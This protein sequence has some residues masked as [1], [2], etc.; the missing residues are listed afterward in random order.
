MPFG[1]AVSH[2]AIEAVPK[3][4]DV[5][6]RRPI[7]VLH[8]HSPAIEARADIVPIRARA[9]LPQWPQ[10]SC[11]HVGGFFNT[12]QIKNRARNVQVGHRSRNF[13]TSRDPRSRNHQWHS[14]GALERK[15]LACSPVVTK[16]LSVIAAEDDNRLMKLTL[17]L[18]LIQHLLEEAVQFLQKSSVVASA[19]V[20]I[21]TAGSTGSTSSNV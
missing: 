20:T 21:Y 11:S 6:I 2:A 3:T 7:D 10:G 4:T 13:N 9:R 5:F 12:C 14:G 8:D 18:N 16:H 15:R 1:A 19:V 17:L